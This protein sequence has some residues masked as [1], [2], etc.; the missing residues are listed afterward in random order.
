MKLFGKVNVT[1]AD[2]WLAMKVNN[3]EVMGSNPPNPLKRLIG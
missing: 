3:R 1:R 2:H